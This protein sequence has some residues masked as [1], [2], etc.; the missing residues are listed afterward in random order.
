MLILDTNVVSEA[1][2]P[3][4]NRNVK[5]WLSGQDGDEMY[6]SSVTVLELQRGISQSEKRGDKPQAAMLTRWL[7]DMVLPTFAGRILPVDHAIARL[8]GRLAWPSATDFRDAVIAATAMVH[9]AIVVTRNIS[10][11]QKSGV[12]WVNPWTVDMRQ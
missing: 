11:F 1:R 12:Q 5:T 2:K 8:A 6:I 4:G 10:H 9:D 3:S 7:D